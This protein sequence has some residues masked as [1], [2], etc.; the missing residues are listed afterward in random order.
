MKIIY[1][2]CSMGAAGDMINASLL[3]LV[4]DKKALIDKINSL[5]IDGVEVESKKT[6]KCGIVGNSFSVK[7]DGNE[8][9]EHSHIHEDTHS[10]EN[11]QEHHHSHS[12][13]SDIESI[14]NNFDIDKDVKKDVL[15]IYRILA[16]SE[17]ISHG[18]SVDK[19]HFHE[20][21]EIDAII[22]ITMACMLFNT[23]KADKII[24][25]PINVGSGTVKCVHGILP[26]PAPATLNILKNVPM[27]SSDIKSELCTPTGA[28][29]L[30]YYVDEYRDMPIMKVKN[31]GYG[32]G[33]K[34]FEQ[35]NCI[36][37]F[38]ADIEDK[39]EELIELSFNV[40][41]MTA[42]EI[43]FANEV[44]MQNGALDVYTTPIMMK[45]SRLGSM[46][47]L[48]CFEKNKENLINQIF[49]HTSTL[50]I[51]ELEYKRHYLDRKI[52]KKE[53]PYGTIRVKESSGYGVS[54]SKC[55]YEDLSKIARENDISFR[56]IK[57]S[58]K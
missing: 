33:K 24:S 10:D 2:D 20:V 29:I 40:D 34:D 45:K 14:V 58:I 21:G 48:L 56:E 28:A 15:N 17:S 46:I 6:E 32:M 31:I 52:V 16:E 13:L 27:Y 43:A 50:G 12:H 35:A 30:K 57:D 1:F 44:F 23:I 38:L 22:D 54:R 9:I 11:S 4:E 51:R 53:T 7:I 47:K 25:S 26:V 49:K 55:E 3:E 39:D 19:I 36:R 37:T 18:K 8:E 41:D 5:G 42:E